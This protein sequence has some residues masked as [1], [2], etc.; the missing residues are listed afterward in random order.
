MNWVVNTLK[1]SVGKKVLMGL[2]G[3][4]LCLF[5]IVHLAGN[6]LMYVGPEAYNNYA[7]TLHSQEWFVMMAE[8]GLLLLFAVHIW[9]G[10]ETSRENR[11][12][13]QQRYR[14]K[15]SKIPGRKIPLSISPENYMLMSGVI[16]LA[17]LLIH[18]GDF[19]F[20]ITM[21]GELEGREPF[22]KAI[23]IMRHPVSFV[24]Y[25]IGVALLGW[26]LSH[27][28]TSMFQT[29]GLRHPKYDGFTQKIGPIF[30][31]VIAIGFASFPVFAVLSSYDPYGEHPTSEGHDY[32]SQLESGQ[33]TTDSL[34][35]ALRESAENF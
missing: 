30:A 16:V 34:K 5:L 15:R 6:L 11:A 21:P 28:V 17:F 31:L 25:L 24:S 2:T 32:H 4:L 9:L 14:V 23:I 13:R 35:F 29:L 19:T 7:H 22:D 27:G 18:L 12:A 3:L 8:T 26:H 10:I 33:G 1:S 20:N